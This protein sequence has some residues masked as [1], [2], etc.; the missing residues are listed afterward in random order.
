MARYRKVDSRIWNDEK[1]RQLSDNGKLAFL[2]LL[3]HPHMTGLGAMRSTMPGLAAEIGWSDRK[4]RSAFLESE[5]RGMAEADEIAAVVC[6][7]NFL[8]YNGPESPNVVKSWS[9][10]LD[11][12]PECE[13]KRLTVERTVE[14]VERLPKAFRDALP[15]AFRK[16]MP[17]PYPEPEPEPEPEKDSAPARARGS[18]IDDFDPPFRSPRFLEAF[19]S[20]LDH[21]RKRRQPLEPNGKAWKIQRRELAAWGEADAIRS[22]ETSIASGWQG[23]FPPKGGGGNG[24]PTR[25]NWRG[26]DPQP[27]PSRGA[28][29]IA[30]FPELAYAE[31]EP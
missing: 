18:S 4:W 11:L 9:G 28:N 7:P 22:I 5:Q 24:A 27:A 13:L 26:C 10:A 19:A 12:I 1:F 21:R 25:R 29:E 8:R 30:A 23:L 16:S 31:D 3:T 15:D 20:W 17:N 6:L 2:F 14:F